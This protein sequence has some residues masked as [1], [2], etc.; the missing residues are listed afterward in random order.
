MRFLWLKATAVTE[1]TF[2][3]SATPNGD[4]VSVCQRRIEPSSEPDS[5]ESVAVE[6]EVETRDGS[7]VTSEGPSHLLE[8][9]D[10]PELWFGG[11][12]ARGEMVSSRVRARLRT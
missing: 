10:V 1:P 9:F 12:A 5:G 8:A 4:R 3:L 11:I 2:V 7:S 6:A